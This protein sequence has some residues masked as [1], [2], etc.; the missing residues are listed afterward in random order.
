MK[1]LRWELY[2]LPPPPAVEPG[3][4]LP[5]CRESEQQGLLVPQKGPAAQAV[6]PMYASLVAMKSSI[7][8]S[9]VAHV[10]VFEPPNS[11]MKAFRLFCCGQVSANGSVLSYSCAPEC[12]GWARLTFSQAVTFAKFV[13]GSCVHSVC[14]PLKS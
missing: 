12:T 14:D 3:S 9:I 1:G 4:K 2:L 5:S 10:V 6:H 7:L 13:T 11:V 8:E